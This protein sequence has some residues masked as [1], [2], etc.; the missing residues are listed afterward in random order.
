MATSTDN[1][2]PEIQMDS[3]SE[4]DFEM[5][6]DE[7]YSPD[8]NS[9]ESVDELVPKTSLQI[10]TGVKLLSR[11]ITSISTNNGW[12]FIKHKGYEGRYRT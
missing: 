1:G 6:T 9:G 5:E 7:V 10:G 3:E 2:S 12:C 11:R 8:V 4:D